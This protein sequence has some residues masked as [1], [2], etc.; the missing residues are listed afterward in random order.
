MR[1]I[2]VNALLLDCALKTRN[3]GKISVQIYIV[4]IYNFEQLE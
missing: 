3:V 4:K 2:I 1:C